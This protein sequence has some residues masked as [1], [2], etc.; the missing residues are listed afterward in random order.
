MQV[1]QCNAYLY[2]QVWSLVN[3]VLHSFQYWN[4]N[5]LAGKRRLFSKSKK[6]K[7]KTKIFLKKLARTCPSCNRQLEIIYG[8]RD[9]FIGCSGYWTKDKCS[10]K[11]N[12]NQWSKVWLLAV[13]HGGKSR[14][15]L[16]LTIDWQN[17]MQML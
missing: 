16:S 1:I 13:A 11:E 14:S 2:P 9:A 8:K 15:S 5:A 10:Y 12:I 4:K 3:S 7:T 17:A 6:M